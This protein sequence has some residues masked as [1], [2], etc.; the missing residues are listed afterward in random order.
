MYHLTGMG[1]LDFKIFSYLCVCG[2]T[3]TCVCGCAHAERNWSS[4]PLGDADLLTCVLGSNSGYQAWW[5]EPLDSKWPHWPGDF[6]TVHI[7]N[8]REEERVELILCMMWDSGN[9]FIYFVSSQPKTMHTLWMLKY[10]R[11][12]QLACILLRSSS[13]SACMTYHKIAQS[14]IILV[15]SSSPCLSNFMC[16]RYIY[17]GSDIICFQLFGSEEIYGPSALF[18]YLT[19]ETCLL[20]NHLNEKL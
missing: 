7:T 13:P 5:Q 6:K 3:F 2:S 11:V 8:L 15:M 17:L 20:K 10:L 14:F 18:T 4:R 9:V 16:L 1:G 12:L 19:F